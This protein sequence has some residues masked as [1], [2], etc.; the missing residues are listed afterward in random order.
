VRSARL[1]SEL[2]QH[3]GRRSAW[4]LLGVF[5]IEIAGSKWKA[6]SVESHVCRTDDDV[7]RQQ[8]RSRLAV[9]AKRWTK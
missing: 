8:E 6:S 9:E 1:E 4:A 3:F 5:L 2:N 7:L